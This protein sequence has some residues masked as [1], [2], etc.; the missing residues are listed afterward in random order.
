VRRAVVAL[1]AAGLVAGIWVAD[2]ADTRR[3]PLSVSRPDVFSRVETTQ[4]LI[5]LSFDDGPHPDVT[6]RVLELLSQTGARATFFV[7]G[8]NAKARPEMI[9]LMKAEGHEVANHTW[10]HQ[11]LTLIRSSAAAE[12]ISRGAS[13]IETLTGRRP[14]LL[15]PPQGSVTDPVV[16]AATDAGERVVLWSVAL[17]QGSIRDA[18]LIADASNVRAG[19]I[20]LAHDVCPTSSREDCIRLIPR[21]IERLRAFIDAVRARGFRIVTVSELIA[22]AGR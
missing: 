3:L 10:S 21:A 14:A 11:V 22:S 5:A 6:P 16:R 17:D 8:R 2:R 18:S 9:A 7:I 15:R 13:A 20:V 19:D 4:P 12:E 1:L